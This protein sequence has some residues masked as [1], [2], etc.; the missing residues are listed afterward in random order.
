MRS[1][2]GGCSDRI[3]R[4]LDLATVA[5]NT[6]LGDMDVAVA[7]ISDLHL[8]AAQ[9]PRLRRVLPRPDASEEKGGAPALGVKGSRHWQHELRTP[10]DVD[11]QRN[12][13]A[14]RWKLTELGLSN[15]RDRGW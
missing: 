4:S 1:D 9:F 2:A 10:Y 3:S 15:C 5:F 11:R 8:K 13:L 6:K 14:G 7:V 12:L